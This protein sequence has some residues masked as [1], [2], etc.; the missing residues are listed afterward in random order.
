MARDARDLMRVGGCI[1]CLFKVSEIVDRFIYSSGICYTSFLDEESNS[2]RYK[3]T[4]DV[5][6]AERNRDVAMTESNGHSWHQ[7]RFLQICANL[8]QSQTAVLAK[9][10]NLSA[11]LL[12]YF[13]SLSHHS[14]LCFPLL[15]VGIGGEGGIE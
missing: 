5:C 15:P 6:A 9:F 7:A 10:A 1:G 3:R 4:L 14:V 13:S 8:L 11:P 12:R 2:P